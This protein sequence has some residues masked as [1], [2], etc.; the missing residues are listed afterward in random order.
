[1]NV[2]SFNCRGIKSSLGEVQLLCDTYD[3]VMLQETWLCNNEAMFLNTISNDFYANG[4]YAMDASEGILSGRPHGGL[5]VL[6]KKSIASLFLYF[7]YF[8]F[9]NHSATSMLFNEM[10]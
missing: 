2:V 6:W 7:N 4:V 1:L 5:A 8:I 3:I 9:D 10:C